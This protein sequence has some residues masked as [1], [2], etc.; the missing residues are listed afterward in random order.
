MFNSLDF[1]SLCQLIVFDDSGRT[2][3][4]SLCCKERRVA[5]CNLVLHRHRRCSVS[6]SLIFELFDSVVRSQLEDRVAFDFDALARQVE[7]NKFA[8]SGVRS[9][10]IESEHAFEF[11]RLKLIKDNKVSEV[12]AV[13]DFEICAR[14]FFW[15]HADAAVAFD[16]EVF[17]V[18]AWVKRLAERVDDCGFETR[19]AVVDEEVISVAGLC[20]SDNKFSAY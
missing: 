14:H 18:H 19:C 20:S 7:L 2:V 12:F 15:L 4:E 13:H 8:I 6:V 16:A 5:T 11:V 17:D 1:V 10:Q 3:G 9:E